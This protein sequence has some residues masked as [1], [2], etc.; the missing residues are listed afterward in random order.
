M[1][2]YVLIFINAMFETKP[3]LLDALL[4]YGS[5]LETILTLDFK[6]FSKAH[7]ILIMPS[8]VPSNLV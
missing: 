7:K 8:V 4:Y 3:V 2:D 5:R 1:G 6:T